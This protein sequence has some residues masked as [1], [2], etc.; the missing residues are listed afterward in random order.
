MNRAIDVVPNET[1][2]TCTP[3]VGTP[4]LEMALLS[5]LV[6]ILKFAMQHVIKRAY[7]SQ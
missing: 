7:C 3:E 4:L 2:S 5:Y 1:R 6:D